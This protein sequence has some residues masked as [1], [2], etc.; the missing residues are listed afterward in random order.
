MCE[1]KFDKSIPGRLN[2]TSKTKV[3]IFGREI[4]W[5]KH[6]IDY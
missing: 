1:N 3:P 2:K 5:L 4:I 6:K